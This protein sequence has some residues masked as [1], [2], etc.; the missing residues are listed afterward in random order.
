[1]VYAS[2]DFSPWMSLSFGSN[3]MACLWDQG[4]SVAVRSYYCQNRNTSN[5]CNI[6]VVL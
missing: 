6:I 3:D 4:S 2:G 1:M 5:N